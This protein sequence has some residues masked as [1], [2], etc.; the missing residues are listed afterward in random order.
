MIDDPTAPRP[1]LPSEGGGMTSSLS[2]SRVV[3]LPE[4]INRFFCFSNVWWG[5][6]AVLEGR[7]GTQSDGNLAGRFGLCPV[8]RHG[9]SIRIDILGYSWIST[10]GL[11]PLP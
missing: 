4:W 5:G 11:W 8:E 9:H 2:L 1:S 7:G 10:G 3:P 6:I